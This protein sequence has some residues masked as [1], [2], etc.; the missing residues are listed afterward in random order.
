MMVYK[1]RL[2]D[3]DSGKVLYE[4]TAADL[5]AGAQEVVARL[6][7]RGIGCTDLVLQKSN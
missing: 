4:G 3:P 7:N 5:A 2:T 1:Y 6:R